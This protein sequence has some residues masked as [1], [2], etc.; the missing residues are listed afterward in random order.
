LSSVPPQGRK[1]TSNQG[2]CNNTFFFNSYFTIRNF[3]FYICMDL[4]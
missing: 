4:I 1:L 2:P 3:D